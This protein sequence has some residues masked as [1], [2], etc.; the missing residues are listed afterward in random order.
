MREV[1]NNCYHYKDGECHLTPIVIQTEP[2]FWCNEWRPIEYYPLGINMLRG[3]L[4]RHEDIDVKQTSFN[5][6]EV[7]IPPHLLIIQDGD[8]R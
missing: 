3:L 7:T 2:Q 5:K 4:A 8:L 6:V 1:C